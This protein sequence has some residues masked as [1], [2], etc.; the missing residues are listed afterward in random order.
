MSKCS[1]KYVMGKGMSHRVWECPIAKCPQCG[2]LTN[3]L[4]MKWD[5]FYLFIHFISIPHN[6][7]DTEQQS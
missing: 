6:V 5:M 3:M 7:R 2:S 1:K 4:E